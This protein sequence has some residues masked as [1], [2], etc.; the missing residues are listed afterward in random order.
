MIAADAIERTSQ[1]LSAHST[2][3]ERVY[4]SLSHGISD[5]EIDDVRT[6][7]IGRLWGDQ[8]LSL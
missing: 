5:Q 8:A 6:F 7:L 1:W 3:T 4:P 2:L